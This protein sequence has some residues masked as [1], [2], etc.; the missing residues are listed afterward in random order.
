MALNTRAADLSGATQG[1]YIPEFATDIV[2]SEVSKCSVLQ[3]IVN[4]S[5]DI[6]SLGLNCA[7]TAHYTILRDIEVD[8]FH[9]GQW[10]GE[11]WEPDDPF[12]SGVITLCQKVPLRKKFSR[13][14]AIALCKRWETTVQ[15]G[16]ETAIGSAMR[17]HTERYG[18]RMLVASAN[19]L[20][21][22]N[23]AG[24]LSGNIALGDTVNPVTIGKNGNSGAM[25]LLSRM[26]QAL[27]ETG[28][29]CGGNQL[30]VVANPA[31]FNKIRNEQSNLGAGC[32]LKDNPAI[33]GMIHPVLGM[34]VYSSLYMPRY[35][36]ADGKIVDYVLMVD[37]QH[38]AAP[39]SLDYLEWQT[40]LNDIYLVG[41]YRFDVAALSNQSIA[42][43]A[44]I[45]EA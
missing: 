39:I 26:E 21:Q 13:E 40:Q 10:N 36:R 29:T 16:Y 33:T 24:A 34:E 30:K 5:Y 31:F 23:Q 9:E 38:I 12:R 3:H 8:E 28:S 27:Q 45:T 11:Y 15:N 14:E 17:R 44:I 1:L 20:N 25:E 6:D 7:S 37:P 32:C 41:N 42:V 18:L 2:I 35:K 43:A 4:Q 22:G 19:R